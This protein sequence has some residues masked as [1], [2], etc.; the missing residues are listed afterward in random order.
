MTS[1]SA[2]RREVHE[3]GGGTAAGDGGAA[4]AGEGDRSAPGGPA[5]RRMGSR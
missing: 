1:L 5:G 4:G 2:D 3:A